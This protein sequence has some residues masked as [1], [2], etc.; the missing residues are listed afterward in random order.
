MAKVTITIED[1]EDGESKITF[2][3]DPEFDIQN[4]PEDSLTQAQAIA[5][6]FLDF[7]LMLRAEQEGSEHH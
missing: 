2:D 1:L 3:A 7:T 4:A 6:Q 5:Q